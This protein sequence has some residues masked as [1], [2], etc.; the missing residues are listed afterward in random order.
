MTKQRITV[1]VRA[2]LVD[3]LRSKAQWQQRTMSDLAEDALADLREKMGEPGHPK[4]IDR[5]PERALANLAR[6]RGRND[7]GSRDKR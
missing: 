7:G 2:D 4:N 6:I 5:L 3:W 1:S